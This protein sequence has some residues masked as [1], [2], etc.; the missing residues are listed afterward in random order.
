MGRNVWH[1]QIRGTGDNRTG[2][3]GDANALLKKAV[4]DFKAAGHE[5]SSHGITY[6]AGDPAPSAPP[7]PV[8]SHAPHAE[9]SGSVVLD[10]GGN[11][12]TV[13]GTF[14]A[15]TIGSVATPAVQLADGLVLVS[16]V[17][18][19]GEPLGTGTVTEAD[20]SVLRLAMPSKPAEA[21]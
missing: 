14:V 19:S 2:A 9:G 15:V 7:A 17:S 20:G 4:E 21:P 13:D 12:R 18:P 1:L 3:P 8:S 5:I 10:R 6:D 16:V 11:L